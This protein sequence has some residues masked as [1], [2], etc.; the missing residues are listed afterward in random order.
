[1]TNWKYTNATNTIVFRVWS[2]GTMES[3]IATRPDVVAWVAAGN[4]I[5]AADPS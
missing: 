1:M 4:T 5:E 2:N 3:C